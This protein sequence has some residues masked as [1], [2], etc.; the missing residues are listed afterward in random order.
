[1]KTDYQ[2][3]CVLC[4]GREEQGILCGCSFSNERESEDH[5]HYLL[6]FDTTT[7][8]RKKEYEKVLVIV[9]A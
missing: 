2:S 8:Q 3:N 1:M 5:R 7:L 6:S 9:C 4:V